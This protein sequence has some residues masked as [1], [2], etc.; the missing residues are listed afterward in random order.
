MTF[1]RRQALTLMAGGATALIAPGALAAPLSPRLRQAADGV[2][3]NVPDW[4]GASWTAVTPLPGGGLL[5]GWSNFR[6]T[7]LRSF[8]GALAPDGRHRAVGGPGL[9]SQPIGMAAFLDGSALFFHTGGISNVGTDRV[10]VV[11]VSKTGEQGEPAPLSAKGD[12]PRALFAARLADDTAI[13]VWQ[14]GS[15]DARRPVEL[16][17]RVVSKDGSPRGDVRTLGRPDGVVQQTPTSLAVLA[18]G[19]AVLGYYRSTG[20]GVWGRGFVQ[21]LGRA[22]K[23]VGA[24]MGLGA[25][26]GVALS[27]LRYGGF[28][29]SWINTA[30]GLSVSFSKPSG[31]LGPEVRID[32][33][34]N[35][36]GGW[37]VAPAWTGGAVLLVGGAKRYRSLLSVFLID[38]LGRVVG[39]P[40]VLENEDTDNRLDVYYRPQE[41]RTLV[42]G[43]VFLAWSDAYENNDGPSK[44]AI[45]RIV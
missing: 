29:A 9:L 38:Q 7:F 22:G 24:P 14:S 10:F 17:W 37:Q 30:G 28:V 44:G 43:D 36:F 20:Y 42:N 11:P 25:R 19:G 35:R 45:L 5:W 8:D 27:G 31:G 23:T 41:A 13:V 6:G 18:D 3:L 34:I 33:G 12:K 32:T 26:G 40:T 39:E 1:D 15:A 2:D 16:R 4:S 21:R